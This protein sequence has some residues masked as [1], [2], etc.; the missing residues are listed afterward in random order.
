MKISEIL[1]GP[2]TKSISRIIEKGNLDELNNFITNGGDVNKI[3][4][5]KSLLH[6][7]IDNC[8]EN[9]FQVIELLINNGADINSTQSYYK[10]LPL[11]RACAR[12]RP[13]M[14][15]IKLLL[16]RGSKVNIE[17]ITGKT[18]IFNCNFSFSV[19]LLN[20]LLKYGAD[21]KHTDKY[22]NTILHD[23]YIMC[24]DPYD[25]EEYLKV[26]L[27]LGVDINSKN[28]EGKTPLNLCKDRKTENILIQYGAKTTIN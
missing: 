10:E 14:D 23:D 2:K 27:S 21:I 16:E 17:N 26:I 3:Y 12:I 18:P 28:N 13:Q 9:Y 20:L 4:D 19:E 7:A 8:G 24:G 1:F 25:F 11:H 15:V 5:D 22:D 6:Y